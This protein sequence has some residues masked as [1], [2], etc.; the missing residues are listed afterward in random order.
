MWPCVV[1]NCY[2]VI[3]EAKE[4]MSLSILPAREAES[5]SILKLLSKI[6]YQLKVRASRIPNVHPG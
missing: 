3:S 2:L 5:L 6:F 1:K 4:G